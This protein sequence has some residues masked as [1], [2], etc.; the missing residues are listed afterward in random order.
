MVAGVV[1][2]VTAARTEVKCADGESF[3][4]R[5]FPYKTAD[6]SIRGAVIELV[7]RKLAP[8]GDEPSSG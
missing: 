1:N 4:M 5:I 7:R 8:G 6:H 2:S 3:H